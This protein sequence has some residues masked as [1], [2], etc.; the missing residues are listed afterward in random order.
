MKFIVFI[1]DK[2]NLLVKSRISMVECGITLSFEA[3]LVISTFFVGAEIC[4]NIIY[5]RKLR[6][7]AVTFLFTR[8]SI[9]VIHAFSILTF[10]TVKILAFINTLSFDAKLPI[11]G[12]RIYASPRTVVISA[13][14][15]IFTDE[16]SFMTRLIEII[17]DI[18]VVANLAF[19]IKA[20]SS[21]IICNS[22][23]LRFSVT[24]FVT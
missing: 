15:A 3:I 11:I 7:K 1:D 5:T 20:N 14:L 2:I 6:V 19:F 23:K 22:T 21:P 17:F 24:I 12:T 18:I 13:S 9:L 8:S 16:R 4:A 10:L